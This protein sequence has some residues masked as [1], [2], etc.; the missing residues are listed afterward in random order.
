MS[1]SCVSPRRL[2]ALLP[3]AALLAAGLAV[4]Q[5]PGPNVN[6]VSGTGWPGGD[7]FLQRQNEP[8][9]AV[10]TRNP[11]HLLA[12]ANDYR[13]V[14]LPGLPDD[15]MTGD[16]WLGVF[17][18]SDGGATW[19]STL[20]P[21][22]PQETGS[23]SPIHG[24][25]AGADPLV[26]AGPHGLF[27]YSGIVFDRTNPVLE[28]RRR[29]EGR[30]VTA[31]VADTSTS[32]VFVARYIDNNVKE[33]GEPI[34]HLGTSVVASNTNPNVFLDKPWLSVDMPRLGAGTCKITQT[35]GEKTVT[36]SIPAGNVYVAYSQFTGSVSQGTAQGT[37]MFT[38]SIDCGA[39]WSAPVAISGTHRINQGA[40]I[41]IDPRTGTVYV[42]WRRFA[43]A[44]ANPTQRDAILLA[45]SLDRGR[46]FAAPAVVAEFTPFEQGTGTYQFRSSAY[47][48]AGVDRL[49]RVLVAYSA[50]G[51]QRPDGDAR[52]LLTWA[53]YP[54]RLRAL[55]TDEDDG[56][57]TIKAGDARPTWT[58]PTPVDPTPPGEGTS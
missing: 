30:T 55:F 48:T 34:A 44:Q 54:S 13:T 51:V 24:F 29:P 26:R 37:L 58:T 49:G 56:T 14:D 27:Y 25:D 19:R 31:G 17:M 10:S 3:L 47:P 8:S 53:R 5:V 22:Y 1:R 12:G 2:R 9:V 18:S 41:A 39:T 45:R 33:N 35:L 38:R 16:A 4:A 40:T 11:M 7:P 21:G 52:I 20:L 23:A 43:S 46:T 36:Q 32:A 28:A 57:E 42:V 15:K 6:M 50:R